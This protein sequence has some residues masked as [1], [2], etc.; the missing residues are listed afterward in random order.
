MRMTPIKLDHL[1]VITVLNHLLSWEAIK[2]TDL[3]RTSTIV[4]ALK[5]TLH[6]LWCQRR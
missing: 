3:P 4:L 1:C 6:A 2:W 5:H